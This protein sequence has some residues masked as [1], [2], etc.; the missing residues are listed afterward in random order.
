MDLNNLFEEVTS[1]IFNVFSSLIKDGMYIT[2]PVESGW[3]D[4]TQLNESPCRVIVD[5]LS[6]EDKKN[7]SFF[8]QIQPTDTIVLIEGKDIR[9]NSIEVKNSDQFKI[10]FGTTWKNFTVEAHETDPAEALYILLLRSKK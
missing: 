8:T 7:T 9:S 3:D 6:Q 5:G 1:T 2:M 10:L 4:P